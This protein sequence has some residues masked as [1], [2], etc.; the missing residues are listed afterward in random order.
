MST[1]FPGGLNR[2]QDY[3]DA[4]HHKSGTTAAGVDADRVAINAEYSFT[5]REL[6]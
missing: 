3:L 6:L 4:V 1:D 2:I 5:L